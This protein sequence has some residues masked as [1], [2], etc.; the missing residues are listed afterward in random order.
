MFKCLTTI[1][2][3]DLTWRLQSLSPTEQVAGI[4]ALDLFSCSLVSFAAA[5]ASPLLLYFGIFIVVDKELGL[6]WECCLTEFLALRGGVG[7]HFTVTITQRGRIVTPVLNVLLNHT[8]FG[9]Q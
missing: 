5:C 8:L 6:I 4:N 9:W 7:S 2:S 1:Q 3:Y